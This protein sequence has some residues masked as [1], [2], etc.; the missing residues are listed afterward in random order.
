MSI[1]LIIEI[2]IVIILFII[3][4]LLV[5]LVIS[6]KKRL[7]RV[8]FYA[9][10]PIHDNSIPLTD[11]LIKV[12]FF[13]YLVNVGSILRGLIILIEKLE[14][15]INILNISIGIILLQLILLLIN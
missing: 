8:S 5:K 12:Y 6:K 3:I 10:E 11:R 2:V 13:L 4:T 1:D 9:M 7:K 14:S 15:M